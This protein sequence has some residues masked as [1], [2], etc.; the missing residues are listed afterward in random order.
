MIEESALP[1]GVATSR[2]FDRPSENPL[3][4]SNPLAQFNVMRQ[5]YNQVQVIRENH[6]APNRNAEIIMRAFSKFHECFVNTIIRKMGSAPVGAACYEIERVAQE[7]NIEPPWCSR[8]FCH[9]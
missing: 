2:P 8:E 7:D 5:R 6:V 3:Q 1:D 4:S 9:D